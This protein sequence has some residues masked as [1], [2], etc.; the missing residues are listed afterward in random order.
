MSMNNEGVR[1]TGLSSKTY[2]QRCGTISRGNIRQLQ[3]DNLK[4]RV[5]WRQPRKYDICWT[6]IHR[7]GDRISNRH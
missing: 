6:S 7:Y 5:T 4:P 3:K 1:G 2:D